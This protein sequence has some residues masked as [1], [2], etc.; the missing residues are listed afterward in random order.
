[1]PKQQTDY[2][3]Q[4]I[5]SLTKSEKRQFRLWVKRNQSSGEILFLQLFDVLEKQKRYDEQSI[6]KKI[7]G[8]KKRQLSNLKAHLYKQ[9]LIALRLLHRSAN[10]DI[11]I[12]E[13]I[14]YARV[15]YNKGLYRQC[16][17]ILDKAK[18]M[19]KSAQMSSLTL[20]I[21]D[22]EKHIES[23]YI[24]R[25]ID[26]KAE[27]LTIESLEISKKAVRVHEFSNLSIQLYGLYLRVGY[28]KNQKEYYFVKEF[29]QANLPQY[30]IASS[31]SFY[32]C[33]L[34]AISR[35]VR[36]CGWEAWPWTN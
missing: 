13:R 20:E 10:L 34:V 16:L 5:N 12:R 8:I 11:E 28:V 26:N 33:T 1:M 3:I 23:Q 17:E 2:L 4:L 21:L 6:L 15:L 18:S 29:F 27:Q 35:I 32:H 31:T 9:L 7:P 25:S 24:T 14:D 19:S 30:D 36:R 22:F